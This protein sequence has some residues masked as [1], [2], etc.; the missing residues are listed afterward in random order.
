[1]GGSMKKSAV[2]RSATITRKW[3]DLRKYIHGTAKRFA[4]PGKVDE[5][6]LLSEGLFL[7]AEVL[8]RYPQMD[9]TSEDFDK[10]LKRSIRLGII[11][12][13][14]GFYTQMRDP[15]RETVLNESDGSARVLVCPNF[16][17][18]TAV[19]AQAI[20]DF[21][22]FCEAVDVRLRNSDERRVWGLVGFHMA[23]YEEIRDTLHPPSLGGRPPKPETVIARHFGWSVAYAL[24]HL[25]RIQSVVEELL[26]PRR[27]RSNLLIFDEVPEAEPSAQEKWKNCGRKPP[28]ILDLSDG[29]PHEAVLKEPK[30]VS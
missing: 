9:F 1:M 21:K 22:D 29:R 28:V 14:R 17:W 18:L 26:E 4:I 5:E 10:I 23:D 24:R 6:D 15:A 16:F 27:S 8:D 7:I 19:D 20:V 3:H 30:D 12:R 11:D 25:H 2:T 13:V